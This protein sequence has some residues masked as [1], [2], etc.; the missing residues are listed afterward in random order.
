MNALVPIRHYLIG[1]PDER[2]VELTALRPAGRL[3]AAVPIGNRHVQLP[4]AEHRALDGHYQRLGHC[5]PDWDAW[6]LTVA[7]RQR[8]TTEALH[9]AR[10]RMYHD[11]R[12]ERV[13]VRVLPEIEPGGRFM[14]GRFWI[15][16]VC[17]TA[18]LAAWQ[19]VRTWA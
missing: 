7:L 15:G 14:R 11:E 1:V 6:L 10:G 16:V 17:T 19:W 13:E 4:N 2:A 12:C 3:L 5:T 9:E 18:I 8:G